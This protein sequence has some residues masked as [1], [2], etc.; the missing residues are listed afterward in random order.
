M[1][2]DN[3]DVQTATLRLAQSR[4]QRDVAA[5]AQFPTLDGNT[6][7]ERQKPS[8]NG[9]LGLFSNGF[10]GDWPWWLRQSAGGRS[11]QPQRT[12]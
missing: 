4:Y 8:D 3:L 10:S 2:A 12:L 9:L 5:A 11:G 7:Y 6:S 1:A